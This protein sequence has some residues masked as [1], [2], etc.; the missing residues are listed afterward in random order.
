MGSVMGT[1]LAA[2]LAGLVFQLP[3]TP[4][5]P[6][7]G[8]PVGQPFAEQLFQILGRGTIPI[9]SNPIGAFPDILDRILARQPIW[10]QGVA[11]T[12]W[13]EVGADLAALD[14]AFAQTSDDMDSPFEEPP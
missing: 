8:A 11:A 12:G 4:I 5:A 7:A 1:Q 9:E 14:Q 13:N 10:A 3:N 6:G 2:R